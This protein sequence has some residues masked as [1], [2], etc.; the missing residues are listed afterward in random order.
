[1]TLRFAW[2]HKHSAVTAI[3]LLQ[4][5]D[6]A[7]G[8]LFWSSW[9]IQT[10]PTDCS[11]DSWSDTFLG[12]QEHGAL[13]LLNNTY[14]LTYLSSDDCSHDSDTY[15]NPSCAKLNSRVVLE[16]NLSRQSTALEPTNQKVKVNIDLYSAYNPTVVPSQP[17]SGTN[18]T[19]T[20]NHWD[21]LQLAI[22]T[23]V[24]LHKTAF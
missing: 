1:M 9:A 18:V 5:L 2:C 16:T 22:I 19:G 14:L 13:W 21:W 24:Q 10:S 17:E 6:L 23:E 12:K 20:P 4:P 15:L 11:V 7:C 3:E 8:T